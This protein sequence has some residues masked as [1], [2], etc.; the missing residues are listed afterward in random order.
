MNPQ[1]GSV[2]PGPAR[3]GRLARVAAKPRVWCF[4]TYYAEGFP[5]TVIR[6]LSALYATDIGIKERVIGYMNFLALPWNL[7]FLWAPLLDLTSTKKRWM[8]GMQLAI[9]V[10]MLALGA[11][12]FLEPGVLASGRVTHLIVVL[13]VLAV[14]AATQDV[15]IDAFYMEGLP[16]PSIQAAWAGYRTLAYRLAMVSVRSGLVALA[17][18]LVLRP[19]WTRFLA[20]GWTFVAAGAIMLALGTFHGLFLPECAKEP[21]GE[22]QRSPREILVGFGRA[23]LTYLE[24]D[25]VGLVLAFIVFYKVG[26]EVL[27]SMV[28]PFLKRELGV[29]L[30]QYAW[31]SGVVGAAGMIVGTTVGGLWIK[32]QGLKK[33]IWPLTL[34]MNT[35][36]WIYVALAYFKPDPATG[37]GITLIAL[38]HGIEQFASG[39]GSAALLVYLLSTCKPEFKAAHYAVGS[40]LM[41]VFATFFGGFSGLIVEHFGYVRLFISAFLL[42]IPAMVI[43][44]WLPIHSPP[45]K[46]ASAPRT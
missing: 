40:A 6:I 34:L 11:L 19:G 18:V 32:R 9:G 29:T 46:G 12:N 5:Y 2:P 39:L 35:P 15:A 28:T 20:W 41:S 33:A 31:I 10:A 23:F 21:E 38:V 24:Q 13:V 25:R 4:S 7:K 30:A 36:I 44:C 17:A 3:P 45:P 14:L 16:D 27:F 1:T 37:S 26:D 8:A 42:S 22:R 43:L